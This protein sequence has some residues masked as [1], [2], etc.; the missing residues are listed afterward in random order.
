MCPWYVGIVVKVI[1]SRIARPSSMRRRSRKH[2]ISSGHFVDLGGNLIEKM[3][4]LTI[5]LNP[6]IIDLDLQTNPDPSSSPG[7]GT[8]K[9]TGLTITRYLRNKSGNYLK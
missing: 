4:E 8:S 7:M 2:G 1:T 9:V 6:I 5:D 3:I